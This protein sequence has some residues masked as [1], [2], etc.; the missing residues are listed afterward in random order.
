MPQFCPSLLRK[1]TSCCPSLINFHLSSLS[2]RGKAH[3]WCFPLIVSALDRLL[4]KSS[5]PP[6]DSFIFQIPGISVKLICQH[7]P[8]PILTSFYSS[9]QLVLTF[10]YA[11]VFLFNWCL[12]LCLNFLLVEA[13]LPKGPDLIS[14]PV[15]WLPVVMLHFIRHWPLTGSTNE[16]FCSISQCLSI[17]SVH[18]VIHHSI[19][20]FIPSFIT[21][22]NF[23]SS[24]W[25]T[26]HIEGIS[27]F[28]FSALK[29]WPYKMWCIV[30][31]LLDNFW[32]CTFQS[33]T[34]T[35]KEK[36]ISV[37]VSQ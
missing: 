11:A 6:S 34:N 25:S 29:F 27:V 9:L 4:C 31:H 21:T 26:F 23:P 15:N 22:D 33:C 1:C 20:V 19:Q 2:V 8:A 5:K 24:M 12:F 32:S 36:E 17:I 14:W 18:W 37:I 7:F 3:L 30:D 13:F 28:W 16:F 10:F 35:S